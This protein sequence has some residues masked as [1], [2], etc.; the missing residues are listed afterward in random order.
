MFSAI[1]WV[2]SL[3]LKCSLVATSLTPLAFAYGISEW[4]LNKNIKCGFPYFLLGSAAIGVCW[5]IIKLVEKYSYK[6]PIPITEFNSI[7]SDFLGYLFILLL[8]FIR[9]DN[10]LLGRQPYTTV[11]CLVI[12]VISMAVVGMYHF[13]PTFS[14][15]GYR[16]YNINMEGVSGILIAR[17]EYPLHGKDIRL[18]TAE[19]SNQHRV[20]LYTKELEK[21]TG[22]Q[23]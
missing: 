2:I 9:S 18:Y 6:T 21:N 8:P 17:T 15:L 12:L 19:I 14:I 20:Y 11:A 3:L 7:N 13:N 22:V 5:L 10:S 23:L 16:I 4:E 1:R